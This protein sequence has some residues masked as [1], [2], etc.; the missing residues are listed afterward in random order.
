MSKTVLLQRSALGADSSFGMFYLDPAS[1]K[2]TCFIIE[3]EHRDVKVQGETRVDAGRYEIIKRVI[4]DP[5][6]G[7]TGKYRKIYDWFDFH[8]MLKDTPRHTYVYIHHGN[9]E[10]DTA[11]C[12]LTNFNAY[13]LDGEYEG[14]RSRDAYKVVYQA[15]EKMLETNRVFIIIKDEVK[16]V[17]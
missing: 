4:A 2:P 9:T 1:N 16:V 11:A 7:M 14:G 13:M 17:L 15:I 6:Q 10:K 5:S 3:D 8:L 12:L